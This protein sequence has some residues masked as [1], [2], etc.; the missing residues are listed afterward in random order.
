MQWVQKEILFS[1][2]PIPL[3]LPLAPPFSLTNLGTSAE[4]VRE[5]ERGVGGVLQGAIINYASMAAEQPD[6]NHWIAAFLK[7]LYS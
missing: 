4:V 3:W 5:N 6:L 7:Q 2:L 1:G